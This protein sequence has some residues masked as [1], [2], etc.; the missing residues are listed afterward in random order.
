MRVLVSA[1]TKHG[2]TAG[3][4]AV[5]AGGLAARGIEVVEIEP[6]NV[7]DVEAFDGAVIGSAIYAGQWMQPAKRLVERHANSLRARPTWLFSSGPLGDPAKPAEEPADGRRLADLVGARDHRVFAGRLDRSVLGLGER[8]IVRAVRAPDGDFRDWSIVAAWVDE[9]A[10]SL[11]RR[12]ADATRATVGAV[13][14]R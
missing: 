10:T 1:A 6:D 3:I 11:M 14:D 4:A 9:I 8:V 13:A 12:E 2:A 7:T 5:I